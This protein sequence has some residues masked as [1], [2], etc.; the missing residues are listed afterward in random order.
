MVEDGDSPS[1]SIIVSVGSVPSAIRPL[2]EALLAFSRRLLPVFK[3]GHFLVLHIYQ[4]QMPF[5]LSACLFV[6]V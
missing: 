1:Y 6:G 2:L 4:E 5:H 3:M